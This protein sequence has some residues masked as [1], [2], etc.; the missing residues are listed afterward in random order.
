[1][2]HPKLL[3]LLASLLIAFA[4]QVVCAV[5][6]QDVDILIFFPEKPVPSKVHFATDGELARGILVPFG[7]IAN[8]ISVPK[9]SRELGAQ[10]DQALNGYDRYA[11]IYKELENRFKSR[12]TAFVTTDVRG[13]VTHLS[14]KVIT[15]AAASQGYDYVIA[16]DDKFSGLS[17]LNVAATR[18]DDVAPLTTLEY[19]VYD[20]RKQQQIAKGLISANGMQKKHY[21]EAVHDRE[22]FI[23]SYGP[24]ARYLAE[25]LVGTLF[26]TDT[27]HAMAASVGRGADVPEVAVVLKRYEQRF[28]YTL[29]AAPAWKKTRMNTRYVNVL[30]PRS[31]L[32]FSLG[33]R[34]EVDLLIPEFGQ[35]VSTVDEYIEAWKLRL[36]NQGIDMTSFAV[37]NDIDA[38]EGFRAYILDLPGGGRQITLLRMLNEDMLQM[39]SLIFT[40]DFASLYPQNRKTME[41]MIAEAKLVIH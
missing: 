4:P 19:K 28:T 39:V 15:S 14:D 10:L 30:E 41:S 36:I 18:T 20:A 37:F 40:R 38:P 33:L 21:E 35:D 3:E 25:Q 6:D 16:I 9:R 11:T 13:S 1:M 12:S 32:R 26:R 5:N 17:M 2:R 8:N 31:D 24:M 34:F 7:A 23:N 27:L 22:F 29:K